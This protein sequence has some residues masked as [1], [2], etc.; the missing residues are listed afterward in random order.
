MARPKFDFNTSERTKRR[1]TGMLMTAE[2][3]I[4]T[5]G[6]ENE[7]I[8]VRIVEDITTSTLEGDEKDEKDEEEEDG[9]DRMSG[10]NASDTCGCWINDFVTQL[11]IH[12]ILL[13]GMAEVD[14]YSSEDEITTEENVENGEWLHLAYRRASQ[15]ELLP[16][17]P[18][19]EVIQEPPA[20]TSSKPKPPQKDQPVRQPQRP[21][22]CRGSRPQ[23]PVTIYFEQPSPAPLRPV[24]ERPMPEYRAEKVERKAAKLTENTPM[25][26]KVCDGLE[27][28]RLSDLKEHKAEQQQKQ[29]LSQRTRPD[30]MIWTQEGWRRV[31]PLPIRRPRWEPAAGKSKPA[32]PQ[33]VGPSGTLSELETH[34]YSPCCFEG[35]LKF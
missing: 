3:A 17:S 21:R 30:G 34:E 19:E 7:E 4:D 16:V 10:V 29:Q 18:V 23:R 27:S 32:K 8:E 15:E 11:L 20:Q 22:D 2:E 31:Q 26:A 14:Y 33:L 5:K 1:R 6:E 13:P 35:S 12:P 25:L 9:W 28:M 24:N